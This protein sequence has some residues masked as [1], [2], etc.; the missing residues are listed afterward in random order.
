MKLLNRVTLHY[1][2]ELRGK[3]RVIREEFA[4]KIGEEE[5]L[6]APKVDQ[7]KDEYDAQITELAKSFERQRLPIQRDKVKLEKAREHAFE[8]IERYKLEAKTHAENDDSAGEKKWKEKSNVTKKELSDIEN[9]IKQTEKALKALEERRSL[10][11]FK[12]RDELEAKVKEARKNLLELEAS[13][14]AKILIYKQEMDKLDWQTKKICEQLG[15]AVKLREA[16]MAQFAKLGV[17]KELGW[18]GN[19][20]V[21]VLF[22]V[23]CYQAELKKRYF[24]LPPSVVNNVGILTKLKGVLGMARVKQLL[25]PR[26]KA[27]TSLMDTIQLLIQQNVVF[28]TEIKELGAGTNLVTPGSASDEI[29][30]GLAYLKNEGWFSEKEYEA[31]RQRLT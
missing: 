31:I 8:R 6:V 28:E 4:V 7:L 13:R 12:V 26:F 18:E 27:T 17:R 1:I 20:L 14:D 19:C 11:I 23:I 16:N 21:Y 2:R 29:K 9:Q 15:K 22:Y 25:A 3:A 30:K 5:E 10:E 24:I